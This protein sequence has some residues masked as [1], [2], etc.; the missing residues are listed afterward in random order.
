[1]VAMSEPEKLTDHPDECTCPRC[2]DLKGPMPP[3]I[4]D[5]WDD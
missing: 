5:W 4:D 2:W 3:R 1:M